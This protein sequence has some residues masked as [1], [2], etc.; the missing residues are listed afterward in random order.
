VLLRIKLPDIKEPS[1]FT[2]QSDDSAVQVLLL[3]V[4]EAPYSIF[5]I[6]EFYP[7]KQDGSLYGPCLTTCTEAGAG[8]HKNKG[9]ETL[10]S[11]TNAIETGSYSPMI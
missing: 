11:A 8:L 2:A 4:H 5:N 7:K 9:P 3:T 1:T 6:W 10:F